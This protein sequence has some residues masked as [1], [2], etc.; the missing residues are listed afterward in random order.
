EVDVVRALPREADVLE[1]EADADRGDQ[2]R[3]SWRA[4]QGPVC[5][6]L[7]RT[8]EDSAADHGDDPHEDDEKP[9]PAHP[10]LDPERRRER[11]RDHAAEHED[12]AVCEVDQLEDAVDERVA[13][14]DEGVDAPR[15]EADEEDLDEVARRLDEVDDEPEDEEADEREPDDADQAR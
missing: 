10:R 5:D 4:A 8:V 6:R 2:W 1:D 9:E 11:A 15:R 14:G 12:V 3:E 7:D 13:E